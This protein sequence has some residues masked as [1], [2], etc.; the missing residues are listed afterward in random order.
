MFGVRLPINF[1]SPLKARSISELWRRWHITLSRFL[2]DYVYI[3]LGGNRQGAA[4]KYFNVFITFFL[5]G[6]WHGSGW[7]YVLYG[8]M[9]GTFVACNAAWSDLRKRLGW[10]AEVWWWDRMFAPLLTLAAWTFSIALFRSDSIDSA[11]HILGGMLGMNG[12]ELPLHWV[13]A[14]PRFAAV[15]EF[16]GV[17]F[18]SKTVQLTYPMLL[19]ILVLGAVVLCTPNIYQITSR[20]RPALWEGTR[21]VSRIAWRASLAWTLATAT[22][23]I[24]ALV[25]MS[26]ISQFLYFQF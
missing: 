14:L 22:L 6:V 23:V 12:A 24:L 19:W 3:S 1:N 2:R 13:H 15:F 11:G 26:N 18:T 4:H 9:Q 8:A 20:Y 25:N 21:G 10:T 17:E 7:T 16:A 5:C